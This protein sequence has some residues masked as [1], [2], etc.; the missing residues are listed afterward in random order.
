MLTN[1]NYCFLTDLYTSIQIDSLE[2]LG[3]SR[4]FKVVV[5][6]VCYLKVKILTPFPNTALAHASHYVAA[7]SLVAAS[8]GQSLDLALFSVVAELFKILAACPL[9][10]EKTP[11]TLVNLENLKKLHCLY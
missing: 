3:Q 5:V 6:E 10:F 7:D 4:I 8:E 1:P 9:Q 2:V 11:Q